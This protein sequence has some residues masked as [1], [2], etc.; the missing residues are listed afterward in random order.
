MVKLGRTC[1]CQY[2]TTL[3]AHWSLYRNTSCTLGMGFDLATFEDVVD[4]NFV[5]AICSGV[6]DA[7]VG[8][9][10]GQRAFCAGCNQHWRQSSRTCAVCSVDISQWH[11]GPCLPLQNIIGLM[12]VK[13][14]RADEADGACCSWHDALAFSFGRLF[15][16]EVSDVDQGPPASATRPRRVGRCARV[17]RGRRRRPS[18]ARNCR[19]PR[20]ARNLVT[21]YPL[22]RLTRPT[23]GPPAPASPAPPPSNS[24]RSPL[25]GETTRHSARAPPTI[26]TLG[27]S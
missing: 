3:L 12:R 20:A 2:I 22:I 16:D 19:A 23:G 25:P 4:Q 24:L 7:P 18:E 1:D 15:V 8:C 6:I 11:A 27:A 26:R 9:Q 14:P 17:D 21:P 13:C 5:C 10:Q